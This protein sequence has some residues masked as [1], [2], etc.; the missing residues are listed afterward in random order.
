[1]SRILPAVV[2]ALVWL[3]IGL[4]ALQ[5]ST[6]AGAVTLTV[7]ALFCFRLLLSWR[8]RAETTDPSKRSVSVVLP[9]YNEEPEL[10]RRSLASLADQT[11]LPDRVWVI[12]D[13]SSD[14][15]AADVAE[16]FDG[17]FELRVIRC[18]ENRGKRMAQAE[19]FRRDRSA[20]VFVTADSDTVFHPEA[21]REGLKP[22]A[23][24]DVTAVAGV[25]R[26]INR[27]RNLLTRLQDS[28]YLSSFL[29]ERASLSSLQGS[30]L[31]TSGGLA[32]Y[33]ADVVREVLEEYVSQTFAG[34]PVHTGDD[35]M[36][37]QLSLQRG[38]VVMQHTAVADTAVP[39]RLSHLLRQRVRWSR[40]FWV[41]S[42]WVF[43]NMQTRSWAFWLVAYYLT[44]VIALFLSL[45]I[46]ALVSPELGLR[47][48]GIFLA[49]V[50]ALSYLRAARILA[51]PLPGSTP[52]Q[53]L[54][55]F[56]MVGPAILFNIVVLMPVRLWALVRIRDVARW[57]TR[58]KVE[59]I[60]VATVPVSEQPTARVPPAVL[61][62][63]RRR[64]D[65]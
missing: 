42:L 24:D 22:F 63:L 19:A 11:Y 31:V 56:A 38:R 2:A 3:V 8:D 30:V 53:Q 43:G 27:N 40:S 9:M 15:A 28:E 21:I 7:F 65:R 60:T 59:T 58:R 13:G 36:L 37:T 51:V 44:S 35:R 39:E 33:R 12:D 18:R 26:P 64:K 61:R 62:P 41:N 5:L 46:V 45:A 50:A 48:T 54:S 1:V 52:W 4:R 10:L 55:S 20:E 34:R 23:G 6:T 16:A 49:M 25:V 57:G 29:L 32:L 14:P 17:P 47:F